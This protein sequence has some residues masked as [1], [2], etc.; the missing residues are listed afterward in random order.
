MPLNASSQTAD[1]ARVRRTVLQAIL[2]VT[3]AI[4]IL[5]LLFA[6]RAVLLLLAFTI[7][8][9]YL[10]APLVD[11]FEG[12]VRIGRLTLRIPH[13]LAILIVYLLLGGAVALALEKVAPLLSDQL[14]AITQNMPNYAQQVD[15]YTKR[16]VALPSRYRLPQNLRQSLT[17]GINTT[18]SS[19][20]AWLQAMAVRTVR[21]TPYLLWFVLIPILGFFFLKDGKA[22]SDKFLTTLPA[23][24]LRYRVAMFLKDVSETLAAYIRA[25][26]LAC[27]LVGSIEGTG[28]WLLGL[29]Y[30][31]VFAVAAG[32]FEFVPVIGP[33]AIGIVAVLVASFHSW[34]DAFA[35]FAFLAV[36]R[37]IHDYLIYPRLISHGVEI[38]PVVVILAVLCG[39]ELGGV[40]G[41][42]LSVPAAALLIVCWRHWRDLQSDRASLLVAADETPL[43]ESLIAEE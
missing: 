24:D 32:V 36:F 41:V 26:L 21:L 27:L 9:C 12:S 30:P 18:I 6:L 15:Q 33:L 42:F 31:L 8:F 5:W 28:L 14:N 25:Q 17:D 13:T 3:S 19:L 11:F 23:A 10:I 34:Q 20:W 29:P 4:V 35:V 2:L 43:I 37:L 7:I 22:I 39:V 40:T 16:L 38:H 1:P